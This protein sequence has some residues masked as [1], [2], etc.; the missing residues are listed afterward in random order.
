MIIDTIKE[1]LTFHRKA[2]DTVI[3]GVLSTLFGEVERVGKDKG[4]R[5][6]TDEE[7]IAIIKKFIANN[8]ECAR[9]QGYNLVTDSILPVDLCILMAQ[10]K[11][12][13]T[14]LPKQL[15][16]DDM[17]QIIAEQNLVGVPNVMKYFKATYNGQ[18]DGG[19]LSK[20]AK[21]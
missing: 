1:Q 4:N 19:A 2:R 21:G 8:E 6:T 16:D 11:I 12:Y 20:I 13:E 9:A 10:N 17:R 3:V 5:P 15:S 14:Y 18:Y 7:A